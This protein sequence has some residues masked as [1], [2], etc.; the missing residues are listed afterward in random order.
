MYKKKKTR[1]FRKTLRNIICF[2]IGIVLYAFG[3]IHRAKNKALY[4]G[5]ITGIAFHNPNK[6]LFKNSIKWL[7]K[8]G[9][10]FISTQQLVDIL[11]N[12]VRPPNGAVWI[13]FDDGWKQNINNVIPILIEYNIPATFF[14]T[15]GPVEKDGLYWWKLADRFKD[16]LRNQYNMEKKDLYH[17]DEKK[18]NKIIGEIEE[19]FNKNSDREAMSVEEVK[20]IANI[21][22]VS[23]GSHTVNHVIMPNCTTDEL[24][25][26]ILESKKTIEKWIN[27]KIYS[28]AY[29]NGNFDGREKDILKQSGIE[30]ATT[31]ENK[32]ISI[33]DD[34]YFVPR[35]LAMN[36]S[37]LIENICHML[38][39]WDPVISKIK[40]Y[41]TAIESST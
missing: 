32:F 3:L 18:R 37:T 8:N 2:F 34:L 15:T 25:D 33:K 26:E 11:K 39:I 23:I 13:S 28:F 16:Y 10:T 29:P 22:Q 21:P 12:K 5:H 31:C 40:N 36:E 14:I 41:S 1:D 17:I 19:R 35:F 9:F 6:K 4:S 38:G 7:I 27:K 30:L 20:K 24:K